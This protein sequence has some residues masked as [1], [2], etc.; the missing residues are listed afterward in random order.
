[1]TKILI[2]NILCVIAIVILVI[3]GA[4]DTNSI[5]IGGGLLCTMIADIVGNITLAYQS[6]IIK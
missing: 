1:M 4:H 6:D 5:D 3:I 2:F